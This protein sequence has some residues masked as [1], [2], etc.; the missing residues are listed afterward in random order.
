MLQRVS[1]Q[2]F[3][4]RVCCRCLAQVQAFCRAAGWLFFNTMTPDPNTLD[5]AA[6]AQRDM[7]ITHFRSLQPSEFFNPA[8]LQQHPGMPRPAAHGARFDLTAVLAAPPLPCPDGVCRSLQLLWSKPYR[9]PPRRLCRGQRLPAVRRL[10]QHHHQHPQAAAARPEAGLLH[11]AL[12]CG[13]RQGVR[14]GLTAVAPVLCDWFV[15]H[16]HCSAP[17][18]SFHCRVASTLAC[19]TRS[20]ACVALSQ[21]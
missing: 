9:Q 8:L 20:C 15:R 13:A 3:D 12:L 16:T 7:F 19:T 5:A 2:G 18:N 14:R 11:Y 21:T 1:V 10:G 17:Y 6:K 4:A